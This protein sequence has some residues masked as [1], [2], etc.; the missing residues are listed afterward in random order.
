[1]SALL[2]ATPGSA[3]P[4]VNI[5]DF[6]RHA[7]AAHRFPKRFRRLSVPILF[8]GQVLRTGDSLCRV[9]WNRKTFHITFS[10][11]HQLKDRLPPPLPEEKKKKARPTVFEGLTASE[12]EDRTLLYP[13][14]YEPG[15]PVAETYPRLSDQ[16]L[17]RDRLNV[18]MQ[19][20]HGCEKPRAVT[21]P[22]FGM[23]SEP[24]PTPEPL[25]NSDEYRL[26][27]IADIRKTT[28]AKTERGRNRFQEKTAV[29]W[30]KRRAAYAKGSELLRESGYFR[31][32]ESYDGVID[33]DRHACPR[34]GGS[35]FDKKLRCQD[36]GYKY[37]RERPAADAPIHERIAHQKGMP[38]VRDKTRNGRRRR[39]LTPQQFV[40]GLILR[41][42][43]ENLTDA[44]SLEK[45][46]GTYQ[47]LCEGWL[48]RD[49]AQFS[50]DA[51]RTIASRAE[52]LFDTV[53]RH[54][55]TGLPLPQ[56]STN[57]LSNLKQCLAQVRIEIPYLRRELCIN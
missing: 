40:A 20:N 56:P 27:F 36:C 9:G 49:V 2:V 46:A 45:A 38:V 23:P 41:G 19:V 31:H 25:T 17:L 5:A 43:F 11:Y 51:E 57:E 53:T 55:G 26:F 12:L 29:L 34:C 4:V 37:F 30:K 52:R 33:C 8:D 54:Q 24:Q 28:A 13:I 16:V 18:S 14:A 1:M 32:S 50:D 44:A 35:V 22:M 39:C 47:I 6:V 48:P 42:Q 7:D 21:Q 3:P 10:Q 15:K